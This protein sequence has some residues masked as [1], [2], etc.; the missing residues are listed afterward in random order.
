MSGDEATRTWS[1]MTEPVLSDQDRLATLVP[2]VHQ[3]LRAEANVLLAG[4]RPGHTLQA[5]ALVHEAYCR[6]VGVDRKLPWANRQHFYAA[7]AEA[8]RR[9][10]VDHARARGSQKRGGGRARVPIDDLAD[11]AGS[12]LEEILR[13]DGVFAR[14]EG[15]DPD[16][17]AVVRLR[18]FAGLT[19]D[20]AAAALGLSAS[21]VDRRWAFARAWLTR[22]L[23]GGEGPASGE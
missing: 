17:A 1:A 15:E 14:L 9:I 6:L 23:A 21:T 16:A 22:E 8:M 18:F 11:L 20:Q 7:A 2:L 4:E 5:T 13:F 12:D 10:L 19:A 3:Q